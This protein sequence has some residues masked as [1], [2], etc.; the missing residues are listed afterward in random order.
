MRV[1]DH[2]DYRDVI[3]AFLAE[4]K[5]ISMRE[6]ARR[7]DCS[8]SWI[9]Q[10]LKRKRELDPSK[11]PILCDI[12]GLD[13]EEVAYV[14]SLIA[15]ESPVESVHQGAW[16][17]ISTARRKAE[18]EAV[19]DDAVRLFSEWI[20]GA[21]WQLSLCEGFDEDPRWIAQ[22][23]IPQVTE[24]EARDAIEGL[25]SL[26]LLERVDGRLVGVSE[27]RSTPPE[28]PTAAYNQALVSWHRHHLNNVNDRM[29]DTPN[30]IRLQL[31]IT[32]SLP[33]DQLLVLHQ[34]IVRA[35]MEVGGMVEAMPGPK[36]RVMH[37][38]IGLVPVTRATGRHAERST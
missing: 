5:V 26:G 2:L 20:W 14:E 6:L 22:M 12:M 15:L 13:H 28:L 16:S 36:T 27:D 10:I 7:M 37:L 38:V 23:L 35:L 24:N 3:S 21:V 30:G 25:V 11:L 32:M 34:Q 9:S 4:N 1:Y 33:N 31:G 29:M 18:S 19:R 17:R 8:V